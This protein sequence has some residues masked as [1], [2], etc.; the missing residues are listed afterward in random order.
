MADEPTPDPAGQPGLTRTGQETV[1]VSEFGSGSLAW[2]VGASLLAGIGALAFLT[3]GRF[4][5]GL[6]GFAPIAHV[7]TVWSVAAATVGFGSQIQTIESL[8]AGAGPFSRRHLRLASLGVALS[9][10]VT[11]IWR[12]EFFATTSLFW[13]VV[14]ALIPVGSLITGMARGGLAAH[15]RKRKLA[16]VIAGENVVR[17][18]LG[19]ALWLAGASSGSFALA[20]LAGFSVAIV[21]FTGM[22]LKG[23]SRR[24]TA[25]SGAAGAFAGLV[26]HLTL[27]VPPTILAVKGAS[28]ETVS[29]VFLVL[30][31]LRAPYQFVLGLG[32]FITARN[33][34]FHAVGRSPWLSHGPQVGITA[35]IGAGAAAFVGFW[36]GDLLADVLLGVGGVVRSVDFALLGALV[37]SVTFGVLRTLGAVAA[38]RTQ[39]VWVGWISAAAGLVLGS[40][41][42][43]ETTALFGFFLVGIWLCLLLLSWTSDELQFVNARQ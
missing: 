2:S 42:A 13:P 7:W 1:S 32:P 11:F 40:L 22:T 26:A 4:A 33:Y 16:V 17:V 39:L 24:T 27:V 10:G 8:T 18:G 41:V 34:S 23:S 19:L 38:G 29:A 21:G 28:P 12:E 36:S 20:L 31:Y 5:L 9:F 15:D 25:S 30:T 14:C 35:M 6:D 3:V 37:V 43:T